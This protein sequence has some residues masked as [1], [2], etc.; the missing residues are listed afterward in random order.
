M[1]MLAGGSKNI[2]S[3]SFG[4]DST[5]TIHLMLERRMPIDRAVYFECEWDYPQM[6]DHINRVIANTGIHI[7][8]V[9]YY[10]HFNEQLACYGWPK[11][12]GGWC[13][14]CKHGTCMK[15]IR[16]IKGDKTEYVGFSA[17]E[18]HRTQTKW[19]KDRKWPVRFPLI[20]AGMGE[21][22]SLAYCKSL[23]YDWGGL[24]DVFSRVSCFCCPKG[25]KRKR[26]LTRVH[27]PCLYDK[28][29]ELDKIAGPAPPAIT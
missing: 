19:M 16:Y 6:E 15:Y 26:E 27:Y 20:E 29:V 3:T 14:A 7:I 22:D 18:S 17:D 21:A 1:T 8:R 23:G 25:G 12:S 9:R 10:R 11:S 28:W 5:A 4:K 2:V 13:T 24:Y